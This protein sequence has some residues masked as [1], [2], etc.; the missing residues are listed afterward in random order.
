MRMEKITSQLNFKALVSCVLL[1]VVNVGYG[2]EEI[3]KDVYE[4]NIKNSGRDGGWV[5]SQ[6][7]QQSHPGGCISTENFDTKIGSL[8]SELKAANEADAG[9][10]KAVLRDRLFKQVMTD[11]KAIDS[12][13]CLSG[14]TA[15]C[16]V[17]KQ[18]GSVQALHQALSSGSA[19]DENL[20]DHDFWIVKSNGKL[21]SIDANLQKFLKTACAALD[22]SDCRTGFNA[23]AVVIV[24]GLE[25]NQIVTAHRLPVIDANSAFLSSRDREW[26]AY[27]NQVSVQYPWELAWN[28]KR[29]TRLYSD[30]QLALFPRAPESKI[31]ALHPSVGFEYIDTPVSG[32][33]QE[34]A[35]LVEIIGFERWKW[36]NGSATQRW[37]A[38]FTASI[39]DIE[40]MD[41]IGW[42]AVVHTP[43]ENI[44]IGIIRRGGSRDSETGIFVNLNLAKLFVEYKDVDLKGFLKKQ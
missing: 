9:L 41:S 5:F 12:N 39:A 34:A 13:D 26:H 40:G 21:G 22:S 14:S 11:L 27:F 30:E 7:F 44:S 24:S 31:I 16:L 28:S 43:V 42:G 20:V 19:P 3:C 36:K 2:A 15:D 29:Y 17:A 6:L 37:G 32:N 8:F 23:A 38:S 18:L 10:D 1:V 25:I 33:S 35:V 4:N